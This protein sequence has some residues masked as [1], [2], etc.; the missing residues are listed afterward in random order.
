M[1]TASSNTTL[2][3]VVVTPV[4]PT[5][6]ASTLA[7]MGASPEER[8]YELLH[9]SSQYLGNEALDTLKREFER[10]RDKKENQVSPS[11]SI[12]L[13]LQLFWQTYIWMLKLC[14]PLCCMI[15]WKIPLLLKMKWLKN[16]VSPLLIWLMVLRR[17]PK[18]KLKVYKM[19]RLKH[20]AKCT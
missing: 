8:F 15:R 11:L 10:I 17:S 6:K 3:G 9:L 4:D 14:V 5:I 12:P 7:P 13:R 16:S 20:S 19:S 1:G 18:S 2:S